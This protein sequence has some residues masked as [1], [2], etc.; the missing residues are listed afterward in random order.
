MTA[1][2][3]YVR[4]GQTGILVATAAAGVILPSI[5][6]A[7]GFLFQTNID[8]LGINNSGI[9]CLGAGCAEDASLIKPRSCGRRIDNRIC[10]A[11]ATER[12][13]VSALDGLE[14]GEGKPT[15]QAASRTRDEQCPEERECDGVLV[16]HKWHQA[17]DDDIQRA[18]AKLGDSGG[19]VGNTALFIEVTNRL[20]ARL[21]NFTNS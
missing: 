17:P 2:A 3:R 16:A 10:M 9:R 8:S 6:G 5:I 7:S 13:T 20:S 18:R 19:Q 1:L 11:R 21:A 12:P 4:H 14:R 15:D